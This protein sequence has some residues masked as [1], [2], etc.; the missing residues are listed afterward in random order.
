M[1][2]LL[3][4]LLKLLCNYHFQTI[5]IQIPL[6]SFKFLHPLLFKHET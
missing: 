2:E 3:K 6:I 4:V 1:Y 5:P